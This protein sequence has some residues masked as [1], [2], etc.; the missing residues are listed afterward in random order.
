MADSIAQQVKKLLKKNPDI[1]NEEMYEMFPDVRPNTLQRYKSKFLEEGGAKKPAAKKA[2]QTATKKTTKPARKATAK[3]SDKAIVKKKVFA[4]LDKTPQTTNEELYAAFSK[5]SRY[6]LRGLKTS[7]TKSSG[8]KTPV[9]AKTEAKAKKAT[10]SK[11]AT[12]TPLKLMINQV[13]SLIDGKKGGI[14]AKA[15]DLGGTIISFIKK[16]RKS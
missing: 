5:V 16:K 13:K 11:S 10:A 15:K 7:H 2:T 4:Y 9:E 12:E 3:L 1:S 8:A 14:A 6:S